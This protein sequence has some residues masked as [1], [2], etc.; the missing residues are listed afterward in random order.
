MVVPSPS[1]YSKSDCT[2]ERAY[3]KRWFLVDSHLSS[4]VISSTS[5]HPRIDY[6]SGTAYSKHYSL[7]GSELSS[8]VM[9]S[10]LVDLTGSFPVKEPTLHVSQKTVSLWSRALLHSDIFSFGISDGWL[11]QWESLLY[12]CLKRQSL[13][14]SELSSMVISW[15]LVHLTS[16]HASERVLLKRQSLVEAS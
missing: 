4:V 3:L 14:D 11:F 6:A 8:P 5:I 15:A 13:I 9:P 16:D 2:G 10:V 7:V 12:M 1:V